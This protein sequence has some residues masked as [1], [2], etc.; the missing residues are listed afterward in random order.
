LCWE[1]N[2]LIRGDSPI[3]QLRETSNPEESSR[4]PSSYS[5]SR[6]FDVTCYP[7][8]KKPFGNLAE[9]LRSKEV[10]RK[11]VEP[12]TSALRS[13]GTESEDTG[14]KPYDSRILSLSA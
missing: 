11:G 14:E 5:S 9:R 2:D 13:D 3:V 4:K 10:E 8:N 6:Q 7:E 1:G 12:S